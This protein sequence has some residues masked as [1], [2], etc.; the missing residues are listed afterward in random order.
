MKRN[1]YHLVILFLSIFL[2]SFCLAKE[3]AT[4]IKST[5]FRGVDPVT[6]KLL[7]SKDVE[8]LASR[9]KSNNIRYAY[10]FAGPYENDGHLPSYAFSQKAKES[11]AILRRLYPELKI[12]PWVG[13][14]QNKTVNLENPKWVKNA[15]NDTV[16]LIKNVTV[17]GIHL[18]LEYVIY[19]DGKFNQKGL[20]TNKYSVHWLKFHKS[21]RLALPKAFI[22]GV[23][24]STASGTKPWKHKHSLSE[25][26]ELSAI[27]DQL[28]FMFYETSLM[29]MKVYKENLKEQ[30]QQ[31]KDLKNASSNRSQ[32]LIGIGTFTLEKKLQ[33][34]R[35]VSSEN[36]PTA[37]K[38][39]QEVEQEIDSQKRIIDGL[40]IYCDW[41]TT[42]LEWNQLKS[43]LK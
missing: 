27:I 8:D 26:K 11:I 22:S 2:C 9:L 34:Y 19:P 30:L 1:F 15:I 38:L 3:N 35:D 31:I 10:I 6:K 24:V 17:D 14:V 36:L 18:D 7:T 40:S 23:V 42:D 32:F 33:N 43:Q 20:D 29:E 37:L 25:I 13:G 41:M 21:L 12:L 5:F 16:R 4:W 39:L 28:S